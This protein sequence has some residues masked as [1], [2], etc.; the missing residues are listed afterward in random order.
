MQAD[1][2]VW[3]SH[4]LALGATPSQVFID[5]IPQLRSPHVTRKPPSFQRPPKVPNF[6][7]EAKDA[8]KYDGLPPL[9][10]EKPS[11]D[12]VLFTNVKSIFMPSSG[13]VEAVFSFE[14]DNSGVVLVQNGTVVCS[15]IRA[16]CMTPAISEDVHIVDL[17]GGSVSP[18]LVSFGSPLGLEEIAME[19]STNDGPVSDILS[20]DIP[21]VLGE[22]AAVVQAVDGLTFASRDAL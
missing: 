20:K 17:Q 14:M 2:V 13:A 22:V 9:H 7:K 1:L 8:I 11:A 19:P 18:G 15:G 10:A 6:D 3:D 21:K 12:S 4:P 16:S 5:G